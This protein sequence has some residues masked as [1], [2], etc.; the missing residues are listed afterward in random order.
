M[1]FSNSPTFPPPEPYELPPSYPKELVP[2]EGPLANNPPTLPSGRRRSLLDPWFT[3]ST[4]IIPVATPRTTPDVSLPPLP[5]WSANKE[6]FKASVMKT[7]E[8]IISI[9]EKQWRG[10]LDHLPRGRK[11][12]WTCVNRYVRKR[13]EATAE[14]GVTLFFAHANGFP[15]EARSLILEAFSNPSL[16]TSAS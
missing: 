13:S 6:E 11:S 4:H 10:E 16:L 12:M 3:S 14:T 9:K 5:R 8:C 1:D 2:I 7:A 15:K